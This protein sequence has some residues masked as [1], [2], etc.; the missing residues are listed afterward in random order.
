[1]ATPT[2]TLG[3][4]LALLLNASVWGLAWLPFKALQARGLHPVW[5]TAFVY[6]LA[7]AALL[8]WR[9]QGARALAQNPRLWGLAA[10]AGLT[11]VCF[12]WAITAGDVV[13]V[14]LQALAAVMGGTQ[15]L[16]TNSRDEALWLPTEESVQIAL[17]TQQ[18]IAHESGVADTIDPLAGSY[19]IENLTDEIERQAAAY[20]N[21]IDQL[22]GALRAIEA[23]FVQGEIGD[24]A[25]AYQR[26]VEQRNPARCVEIQN[27]D[28][29]QQCRVELGAG[30]ENCIII[31]DP[32]KRAMCQARAR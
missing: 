32:D 3:P 16:H 23:G 8:A 1:M 17:R 2:G 12:N 22:G 27:A 24:A 15:S 18:I 13:R 10:A 19:V 5:A 7:L 29:R 4:A 6:V 30:P 14:T 31:S 26:A 11:N 25:Y 21:R 28:L 9:P 20:I